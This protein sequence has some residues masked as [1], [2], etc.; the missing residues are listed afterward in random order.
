MGESANEGWAKSKVI[1]SDLFLV[2]TLIESRVRERLTVGIDNFI[3]LK[4][5]V[6]CGRDEIRE[7]LRTQPGEDPGDERREQEN[8][9]QGNQRLG[10]V[11][12]RSRRIGPPPS[13][14]AEDEKDDPENQDRS[15]KEPWII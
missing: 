4:L 6:R 13:S 14:Q 1:S 7:L 8:D 15:R 9:G 10:D 12:R 11:T 3:F 2:F 5:L